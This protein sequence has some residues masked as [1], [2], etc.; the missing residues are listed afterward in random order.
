VTLY[1]A[2]LEVAISQTCYATGKNH[3]RAV[4]RKLLGVLNLDGVLIQAGA[5]HT[6][7]PFSPTPGAIAKS[8]LNLLLTI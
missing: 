2:A 4:L 6:Q 7:K 8:H 3:E 1:F 5:L